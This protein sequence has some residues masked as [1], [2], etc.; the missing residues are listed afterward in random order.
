[1]GEHQWQLR[2][3]SAELVRRYHDEGWWDD[4]SLGTTVADGLSSMGDVEFNVHSKVRPWRGTFADVDRAARALAG[5]LR[6][7]GV[8]PGDV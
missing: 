7:R 2:S 4:A 5:S 6:A 1:M 8:G 3:P